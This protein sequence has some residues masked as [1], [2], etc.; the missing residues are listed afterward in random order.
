M[1]IDNLANN[2][3]NQFESGEAIAEDILEII[4]E[5]YEAAKVEKELSNNQFEVAYHTSVTGDVEF[6]FARFFYHLIEAR[7]LNWKVYL[8]RQFQRIVPDIRIESEG[9]TLAIIEIKSKV[10]WMQS[11]FSKD[12]VKHDLE[13]LK[14]GESTLNP[15]VDI[16]K[17]RNQLW[18]YI[19]HF[20]INSD[21]FYVLVPS[22]KQVYRKKY[23][24]KY[25][26]FK[27]CFSDHSKL[28]SENLVVLSNDLTYEVSDLLSPSSVTNEFEIMVNKVICCELSNT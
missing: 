4:R 3:V 26:Y 16:L 11:F 23:G 8:R 9:K 10:G 7:E 2:L 25:E 18:K 20:N 27:S 21:R 13:R 28:P 1:H 15:E 24:R 12:R 19:E 6:L 22:L 17:K 14:S 5:I